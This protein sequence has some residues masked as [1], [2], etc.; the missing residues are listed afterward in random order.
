MATELLTC[1]AAECSA[2]HEEPLNDVPSLSCLRYA[3]DEAGLRL[4]VVAKGGF[5][6]CSCCL[7]P[8]RAVCWTF[9]QFY[10]VSC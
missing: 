7:T 2:L 9:G 5:A 1:C 4:A 10:F 8:C 3:Q 6:P